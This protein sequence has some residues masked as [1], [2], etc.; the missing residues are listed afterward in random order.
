M[1]RATRQNHPLLDWVTRALPACMTAALGSWVSRQQLGL[2]LL[3]GHLCSHLYL[4]RW[5][6]ANL[7]LSTCPRR[8]AARRPHKGKGDIKWDVMSV[9]ERHYCANGNNPYAAQ[10]AKWKRKVRKGN[11]FRSTTHSTRRNIQLPFHLQIN[12]TVIFLI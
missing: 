10:K 4:S 12:H 8:E 9:S 6:A 3:P 2:L 7:R 1:A 5:H 11:I